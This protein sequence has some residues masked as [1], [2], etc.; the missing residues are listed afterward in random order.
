MIRFDKEIKMLKQ[1][2]FE[3]AVN[4]IRNNGRELEKALL[5]SALFG[6]GTE[7][8]MNELKKYR[9]G[10]GGCGRALEADF[11]ADESSVLCTTYAFD[12]M[13]E[14]S[15]PESNPDLAAAADYLNR[16]L[17]SDNLIW[18]YVE[19]SEE[20]FPHAPWWTYSRLEQTFN[21]FIENPR[22]KICSYMLRYPRLFDQKTAEKLLEEILAHLN[23]RQA[24][25]SKDEILCYKSLYEVPSLDS[26]IKERLYKSVSAMI[27]ASVVTDEK[28]WG[29]YCLKPI[30]IIDDPAS[31]FAG[32]LPEALSRNIN[33]EIE[34][35]Q[36]DGSWKPNWN[37]AGLYPDAWLDA[38]REWSAVLTLNRLRLFDKFDLIEK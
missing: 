20:N 15:L 12:L 19:E 2:N 8:V 10:D 26:N 27:E 37:W 18:R 9:N 4:F 3:K 38:E 33:Y 28:A 29:E 1:N 17:D 22:V 11:R 24:E 13:V 32:I 30:D 14:A 34:N 5:D 7:A 16:H 25:A 31:D 23:E 35:Q 36:E 6:G 21:G